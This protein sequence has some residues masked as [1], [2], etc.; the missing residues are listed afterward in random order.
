MFALTS[1]NGSPRLC[2]PPYLRR[3]GSLNRNKPNE[4]YRA[5]LT[6][7]GIFEMISS[8]LFFRP[9]AHQG[10]VPHRLLR[11]PEAGAGEGVPL[12]PLHH[13]QAQGRAR[14]QCRSLRATGEMRCREIGRFREEET[15]AQCL[16]DRGMFLLPH[17]GL[18]GS[19]QNFRL[20]GPSFPVVC[21]LSYNI[22]IWGISPLPRVQ[23]SFKHCP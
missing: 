7:V 5:C 19:V 17:D 3:A 4:G 16:R 10:Q 14:Q 13:H 11:P 21:N 20:F 9:D 2:L 8:D 15:E 6:A 18:K 23:T 12:Q 22:C 1:S